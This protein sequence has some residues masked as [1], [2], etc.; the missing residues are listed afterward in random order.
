MSDEKPTQEEIDEQM[1]EKWLTPAER[2][3]LKRLKKK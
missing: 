3:M 1:R 2:A